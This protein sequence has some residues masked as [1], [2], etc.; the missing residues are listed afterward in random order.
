MVFLAVLLALGGVQLFGRHPLSGPWVL[1]F[2][3]A[4]GGQR[5]PWM[6]SVVGVLLPVVLVAVGFRWLEVHLWLLALP[7]AALVLWL[8]MGSSA[9]RRAVEAYI[10]AGRAGNW[11]TAL[12]AYQQLQGQKA[13]IEGESFLVES[14]SSL[15]KSEN[16]LAEGD[17]PALNKAVL[18]QAAYLGF[19]QVFAVLFWFVLAGPAGA[20]GYRLACIHL[21]AQPWPGLVRLV[22][23]LEWPAVRLL[24]LTF[25][26]TGNFLSCIQ[27]WQACVF[28]SVR[29]TQE[30][31]TYFVLGALGVADG[32]K[33]ELDITRR[34]LFAMG[35]L[36]RRSL[37]FWVGVLALVALKS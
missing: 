21:H 4:I 36:F 18:Q 8:S 33:Q 17:W 28:C 37:W 10:N 1:P 22:W 35:R 16:I 15:V 29:S 25:A 14:E 20:L 13:T 26:F 12:Q 6:G 34:E 24:G 32:A 7:F 11:A 27:R 3:A 5:M 2:F 23:W 30:I 9:N 31:I 19:S